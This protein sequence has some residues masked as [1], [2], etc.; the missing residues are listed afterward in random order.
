MKE[1]TTLQHLRRLAG[2]GREAGF[3][4]SAAKSAAS[5]RNDGFCD[6]VLGRIECAVVSGRAV[7]RSVFGGCLTIIQI[8]YLW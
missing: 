8:S 5:G 1:R 7:W 3:P 6:V 4:A 2:R